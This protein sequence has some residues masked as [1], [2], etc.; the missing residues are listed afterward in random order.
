MTLMISFG[1][2]IHRG[3]NENIVRTKDGSVYKKPDISD[4]ICAGVVSYTLASPLKTLHH[5]LLS[6]FMKLDV[7]HA[8]QDFSYKTAAA[9]A[10]KNSGLAQKGVKIL[11]ASSLSDEHLN[12]LSRLSIPAWCRKIYPEKYIKAAAERIKRNMVSSYVEGNNATYLPSAKSI[13]INMN[14]IAF[15]SFHE[16]GHAMNHNFAGIGKVLQKMRLPMGI[17]S[18]IIFLVAAFKPKKAKG[19][20][21]NGAVDKTTTFIKNN[22]GKLAFLTAVPKL[23]EEGLASI[24]GLKLAKPHLSPESYKNLKIFNAK[25]WFTYL[26]GAL[27]F[28]LAVKAASGI[29]NIISSPKKVSEPQ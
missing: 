13:V 27:C 8:Q 14:K 2:N 28:T 4:S 12:I 7:L 9:E 22:A 21:T 10:F 16:M 6:G 23:A 26:A 19:E 3:Y 24:K 20:E 1:T 5:S 17:M 15:T 29:H 18:G 25:A 11:E